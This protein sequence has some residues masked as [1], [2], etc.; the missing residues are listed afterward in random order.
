MHRVLCCIALLLAQLTSADEL[1]REKFLKMP[2]SPALGGAL[3]VER[4]DKEAY[5]QMAPNAVG[6]RFPQ[7]MFGQRQFTTEWDPAPGQV[8][9]TD[10]LGPTFNAVAC[11][12]CHIQSEGFSD[13]RTFSEG[14]EGGLTGR[15]SMG[16]ANSH[17]SIYQ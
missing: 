10:G 13:N 8:P 2:L 5:K 7:F 9:D 14:F 17:Q 12:S 1:L 6:Q 16:L 4:S 11:A 15:N 3:T